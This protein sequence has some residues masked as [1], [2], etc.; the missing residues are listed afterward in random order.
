MEGGRLG[1]SRDFRG[2]KIEDGRLQGRKEDF[3]AGA[4]PLKPF[5]EDIPS[6]QRMA[7]WIRLQNQ[8]ERIAACKG[9]ADVATKLLGLKVFAGNYLINVI[10]VQENRAIQTRSNHI[11]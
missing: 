1:R 10:E 9:E 2:G 8:Y 5:A 3:L 7:E 4:C 11:Q 6:N